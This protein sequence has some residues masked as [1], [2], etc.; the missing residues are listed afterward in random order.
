MLVGIKVPV[1][2]MILKGTWARQLQ[3][4]TAAQFA[5]ASRQLDTVQQAKLSTLDLRL[6]CVA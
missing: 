3:N 4:A 2:L 1:M 6:Q 5:K